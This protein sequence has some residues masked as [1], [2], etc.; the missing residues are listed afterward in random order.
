MV[1]ILFNNI[2]SYYDMGLI[3]S[4]KT[5]EAATAK[6]Q[7]VEVVGGDGEIDYTDF[8]GDTNYNNRSLKFVFNKVHQTS[9]E[10]M[11][12]WSYLLDVLNGKT[13]K[14]TLTENPDFYYTG[15]ISLSYTRKKNITTITASVDA[16]PYRLKHE[17]T[18]VNCEGSGSF[19]LRNLRKK[20]V[21]EITCTAIAKISTD[22]FSVDVQ[23]GTS[24]IPELELMPG[25]NIV[26]IVSTGTVTFKYREGGF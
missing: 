4:S 2:H 20:V 24:V 23:I 22:S 12:D 18:V 6:T 13:F 17:M 5:I 9:L 16:Q 14:I 25:E 21:P 10:F 8:F 26:D 11:E 1:E 19:V 3:L 7:K 15:R